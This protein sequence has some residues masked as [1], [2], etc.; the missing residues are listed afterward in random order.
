MLSC[1]SVLLEQI[2][3]VKWPLG[4][5]ALIIG[6]LLLIPLL[7]L[8]LLWLECS[9]ILVGSRVVLIVISRVDHVDHGL[10]LVGLN[11]VVYEESLIGV[12]HREASLV[13][14]GQK[15]A[16]IFWSGGPEDLNQ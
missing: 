7:G 8:L 3:V 10:F 6:S 16:D 1:W 13:C 4:L 12:I 9:H 5:I 15:F 2:L 11:P 14:V